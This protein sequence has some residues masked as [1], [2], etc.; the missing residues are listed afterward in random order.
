MSVSEGL[1]S[2][3]FPF[4]KWLFVSRWLVQEKTRNNTSF[5]LHYNFGKITLLLLSQGQKSLLWKHFDN[6][7]I[8]HFE[9]HTYTYN[10]ESNGITS[11]AKCWGCNWNVNSLV[12]IQ[13][14][15]RKALLHGGREWLHSR[16]CSS[17]TLVWLQSLPLWAKLH[18]KSRSKT[19]EPWYL[20]AARFSCKAWVRH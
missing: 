18:C 1:T 16:N 8:G 14:R 20:W 17:L 10:E 4:I 15:H 2:Q 12:M 11:N 6:F 3:H 19:A 13:S 5:L 9:M 7:S